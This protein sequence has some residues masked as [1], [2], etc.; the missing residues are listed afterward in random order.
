[1]REQL[2]KQAEENYEEYEPKREVRKQKKQV[3]EEIVE[4]PK[5]KIEESKVETVT[6]KKEKPKP[7]KVAQ[8][9]IVE[10]SKKPILSRIVEDQVVS[11]EPEKV[12]NFDKN[13]VDW[14]L[15]NNAE[16]IEN[17]RKQ[18][19]LIE[20]NV[21]DTND[22]GGSTLADAFKKKKKALVKRFE[23]K[24][25]QIK[26][27]PNANLTT[28]G[29]NTLL[30]E[31]K[32]SH[33]NDET[34][35][36]LKN[37]NTTIGEILNDSELRPTQNNSSTKEKKSRFNKKPVEKNNIVNIKGSTLPTE[38]SQEVLDR[39]IYGKKA[40]I[41]EKEMKE[42]NKRLYSKL[43]EKKEKVKDAE[44]EK[45]KA[46]LQKNKEK[47]KNYADNLKNNVIKKKQDN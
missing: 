10:E 38:P 42:V 30:D 15:M 3:E 28:V 1:L 46:D 20:I 2:S 23:N 13:W 43:I 19:E 41:G 45:K 29:E 5:P 21:N 37:E 16:K 34:N 6:V 47:L 11:H 12:V 26:T 4:K 36:T 18:K 39:L 24:T 31:K 14:N 7:K 32:N 8:K 17:Y 44:A 33:Y 35:N 25:E 9:E 22:L 40:E 27:E